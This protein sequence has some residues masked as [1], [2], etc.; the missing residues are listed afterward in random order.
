MVL[1]IAVITAAPGIPVVV[2]KLIQLLEQIV[3]LLLQ[4]VALLFQVGL[5]F[6]QLIE[7]LFAGIR[8]GLRVVDRL[9]NI[10]RVGRG[11]DF[12]QFFL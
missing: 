7:L 6:F 12:A 3:L 11:G 4:V 10:R 5:L 8:P 2:V 9:L 1:P